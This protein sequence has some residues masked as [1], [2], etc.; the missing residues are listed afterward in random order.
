MEVGLI[1]SLTSLGHCRDTECV[2]SPEVLFCLD[3]GSIAR[4]K[5]H[6]FPPSLVRQLLQVLFQH[7]SWLDDER[8]RAKQRTNFPLLR[9]NLRRTI[10]ASQLCNERL[11]AA[12]MSMLHVGVS[13]EGKVICRVS[14][15][16]QMKM[17]ARE[18]ESEISQVC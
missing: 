16:T 11:L 1:F 18:S 14:M 17:E 8:E 6:F 7:N 2:A 12:L 10:M 13:Q 3:S 5:L 15:R 4:A 9:G